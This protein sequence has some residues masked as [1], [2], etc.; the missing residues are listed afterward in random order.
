[1]GA[2]GKKLVALVHQQHFLAVNL[3][4]QHLS[5][6]KLRERNAFFEIGLGF[7]FW[8]CFCHGPLLLWLDRLPP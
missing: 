5:S 4:G 7:I 3:A 1:M 6:G 8:F 2:Y